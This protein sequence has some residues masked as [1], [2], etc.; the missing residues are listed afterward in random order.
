MD[1]MDFV[2]SIL[3]CTFMLS[4]PIL[5]TALGEAIAESS[6][7]LNLGL[8]GIMALGA[9][10]GCISTYF[11]GNPWIGMFF[12]ALAGIVLAFIHAFMSIK[13][14]VRQEVCGIGITI[15][16]V[17][18]S[19]YINRIVFGGAIAPVRVG[20]FNDV[21]IPLLNQMP[22]I[23]PA[24]F[25]QNPLVYIGIILAIFLTFFLYKTSYGIRIRAVGE[26]P[27]VADSLG[28][29]V[30]LIRY[31]CVLFGGAM[32][33][34]GGAYL[35][36]AQMHMF[37]EGMVAG[38]GWIALA[39]VI[40]GRWNPIAVL[41]GTLLFAGIDSVQMRIQVIAPWFPYQIL[42]MTPYLFTVVVLILFAKKVE[43]PRALAMPFRRGEE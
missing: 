40:F 36:I 3:R 24:I 39:I 2:T 26:N 1:L 11:T 14:C 20:G 8:E 41:G 19:I 16:G 31:V 37:Y 29:N 4:P 15:L 10:C 32:A 42:L 43:G 27:S 23:G 6:G 17:G 13:L 5:F 7:I 18:L 12:A 38:R 33:G 28:I 30:Q 34:M 22:V 35:S 25:N 9:I 21:P